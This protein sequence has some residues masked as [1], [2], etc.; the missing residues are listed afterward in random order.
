MSAPEADR[1]RERRRRRDDESQRAMI[2]AKLATLKWG[3]TAKSRE[4]NL[5]LS[6]GGAAERLHVSAGS[7]KA[8]RIVQEQAAPELVRASGSRRPSRPTTAPIRSA[9]SSRST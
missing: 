4:T 8:A 7:V 5:S 2:A 3:E 1:A 9:S 6:I